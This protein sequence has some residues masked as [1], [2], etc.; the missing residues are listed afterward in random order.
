MNETYKLVEEMKDIL[1]ESNL[2]TSRTVRKVATYFNISGAM[3]YNQ[4]KANRI[5][6]NL[7]K[8]IVNDNNLS[9]LNISK[10]YV[11]KNILGI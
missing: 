1:F 9:S 5:N 8:K 7:Y 11:N 6:L 2:I 3:L 10:E 4:I